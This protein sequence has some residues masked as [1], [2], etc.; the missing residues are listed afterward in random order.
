MSELKDHIWSAVAGVTGIGAGVVAFSAVYGSIAA[1]EAFDM[2]SDPAII[3]TVFTGQITGIGAI[4]G[5]AIAVDDIKD[6]AEMFRS[7]SGFGAAALS[8]AAAFGAANHFG[9][10]DL[11]DHSAQAG[12]EDVSVQI[13]DTDRATTNAVD[14]RVDGQGNYVLTVKAPQPAL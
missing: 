10:L 5:G 1:V 4:Y 7:S 13:M 8:L 2:S 6:K 12:Q 3:A 11:L 14:A 9:A